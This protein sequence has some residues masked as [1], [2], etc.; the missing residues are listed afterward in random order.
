MGW[1]NLIVPIAAGIIVA[2]VVIVAWVAIRDRGEMPR[3]RVAKPP[4]SLNRHINP[5]TGSRF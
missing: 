1:V 3:Y 4:K 2:G 5:K